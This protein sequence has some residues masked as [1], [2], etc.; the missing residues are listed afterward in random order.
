V[1][2]YREGAEIIEML[3][4]A[5]KR[6]DDALKGLTR[7]IMQKIKIY[8]IS[9]YQYQ[10]DLLEK[11]GLL[12]YLFEG[13]ILILNSKAYHEAYGLGEISEPNVEEYFF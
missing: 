10:K 2:P 11:Y 8:T 12:E 4:T 3:R 1:V 13:R 9:I 7:E 6:E 5:S